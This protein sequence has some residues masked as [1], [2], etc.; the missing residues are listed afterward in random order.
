MIAFVMITSILWSLE[1][2]VE[3][4]WWAISSFGR[5]RK[6]LVKTHIPFLEEDPRTARAMDGESHLLKVEVF[7]KFYLKRCLWITKMENFTINPKVLTISLIINKHLLRDWN[8]NT[9][10]LAQITW[11]R[12]NATSPSH[13]VSVWSRDENPGIFVLES[14]L[15]TLKEPLSVTSQFI[16]NLSQILPFIA[17]NPGEEFD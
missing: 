13:I 10:K 7:P 6:W 11:E 2:F 3:R 1:L 14:L 9:I 16:H 5:W 12:V 8:T 4:P 17:L 15:L